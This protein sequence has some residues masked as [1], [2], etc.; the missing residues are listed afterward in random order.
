MS[1]AMA[2]DLGHNVEPFLLTST[3]L[4]SVR[5]SALA[6]LNK[7][8]LSPDKSSRGRASREFMASSD[9]A[10]MSTISASLSIVFTSSYER[11]SWERGGWERGGWDITKVCKDSSVPDQPDRLIRP[12]KDISYCMIE[13]Y[14]NT[15]LQSTEHLL[16]VHEIRGSGRWRSRSGRPGGGR[17]NIFDSRGRGTPWI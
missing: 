17:A 10:C 8:V 2:K 14:N 5:E 12:C 15:V 1:S 4:G 6:S 16:I 3:S 13:K 7:H 11:G 9:E